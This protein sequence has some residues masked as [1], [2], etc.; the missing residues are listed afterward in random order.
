RDDPRPDPVPGDAASHRQRAPGR[1]QGLMTGRREDE[2]VDSSRQAPDRVAAARSRGNG[3][4]VTMQQV[5]AEAGV[6]VSTV[7]KV[8][9]GRDGVCTHNVAKGMQVNQ[10]LGDT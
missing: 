4:R 7:S 2:T 1:G 3:S 6:S 9:N 8:I 10:R 5:A